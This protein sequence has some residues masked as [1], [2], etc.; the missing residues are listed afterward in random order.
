MVLS[1]TLNTHPLNNEDEADIDDRWILNGSVD[2]TS[3]ERLELCTFI[4]DSW[5][6]NGSQWRSTE[7]K[8][9]DLADSET[10]AKPFLKRPL[11]TGLACFVHPQPTVHSLTSLRKVTACS[12]RFLASFSSSLPIP[13]VQ[14][15]CAFRSNSFFLL[16]PS[17]LPVLDAAVL[18]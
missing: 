15:I 7:D 10:T 3:G 9:S 12:V 4:R 11:V 5:L 1:L 8:L 17:L 18:A 2:Q 16:T 14:L 13:L 6:R